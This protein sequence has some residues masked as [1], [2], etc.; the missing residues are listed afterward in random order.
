MLKKIVFKCLIV[1]CL[2]LSMMVCVNANAS[3]YT[4]YDNIKD[5]TVPNGSKARLLIQIP[6]KEKEKA[7]KDVKWRFMGWSTNNITNSELIIYEAKTIFSRSNK[8]REPIS[9][10]YNVTDLNVI[11]N[12]TSFTGS[13]TSKASGKIK[14]ITVSGESS[15]KVSTE[16]VK[17]VSHEEDT[18]F[19]VNIYPDRKVSLIIKGVAE[20]TNGGGKY[21][22]MGIPFKKGNYEFIDSLTEYYELYEEVC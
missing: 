22:F 2:S 15:F 8:T 1:V 7:I 19:T 9:F 13:I 4:G 3:S 18:S 17:K 5:Y 21:F 16:K 11:T 14:S 6:K 20:V 12:T 10:K